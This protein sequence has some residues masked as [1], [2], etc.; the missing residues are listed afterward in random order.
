MIIIGWLTDLALRNSL[1]ERPDSQG[2][3]ILQLKLKCK[4]TEISLKGLLSLKKR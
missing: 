4:G 3:T 1:F 2:H